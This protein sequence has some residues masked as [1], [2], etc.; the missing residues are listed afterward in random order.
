MHRI[1]GGQGQPR[2]A[3]SV[4]DTSRAPLATPYLPLHSLKQG[5]HLVVKRPTSFVQPRLTGRGRRGHR[6]A[7]DAVLA[8][9]PQLDSEV[10]L[11][12][13]HEVGVYWGAAQAQGGVYQLLS[14]EI[15]V[16]GVGQAWR[17]LDASR[18]FGA[19]LSFHR[20]CCFR[21]PTALKNGGRGCERIVIATMNATVAVV[22]IAVG[23]T[24]PGMGGHVPRRC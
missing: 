11:W 22:T 20:L 15:G 24:G 6:P 13:F 5:R 8:H 4:R 9:Q 23:G 14:V 19:R 18:E 16:Q 3:D 21:Y 17:D 12:V 10:V 7:S 2:A 1:T